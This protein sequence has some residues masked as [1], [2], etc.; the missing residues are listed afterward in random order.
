[1]LSL[2]SAE[3]RDGGRSVRDPAEAG[4]RDYCRGRKVQSHGEERAGREQRQHHLE[5][6]Q[7]VYFRIYFLI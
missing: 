5:L 1:M 4:R 3:H 7:Y 6:R 2:S